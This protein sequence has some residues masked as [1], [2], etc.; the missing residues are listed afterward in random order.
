MKYFTRFSIM[1]ALAFIAFKEASA[2][3]LVYTQSFINTPAM[4]YSTT[5][6]LDLNANSIDFLSMQAVYSS[7]TYANTNFK[8]GAQSTGTITVVSTTPLVGVRGSVT[9]TM[10]TT[11]NLTKTVA[12]SD[13]IKI[14]SNTALVGQT[15]TLN[16]QIFRAG[17]DWTVAAL[18]SQTA[19]SLM[20]AI[21]AGQNVVIATVPAAGTVIYTT[22]TVSGNVGNSYQMFSSTNGALTVATLNFIGGQ[23]L[24]LLN[25]VV[26]VNG[27][28][29]LNGSDW[30]T[31]DTSSGTANS[32]SAAINSIQQFSGFGIGSGNPNFMTTPFTTTVV[33]GT[34]TVLCASTGAFCNSYGITA[35]TSAIVLSSS[36]FTGGVNNAVLYIGTATLT[37]GTTNNASTFIV[38]NSTSVTSQNISNAIQLA[39]GGV[40]NSTWSASAPI[41]AT[42]TVVGAN[43][44]YS[45]FSSTQAALKV[46]NSSMVGGT[47]PAIQGSVIVAT[48]TYGTALQLLFTKSAGTAPQN[49]VAGVTYYVTVPTTTGFKLATSQANS[50]AGTSIA[51]S[52]FTGG[53]TFAMTPLALTG[54]PSFKWQPSNDCVN[55]DDFSFTT[56]S[57]V[58][59]TTQSLATKV[60]DFQEPQFRCLGLNFIA[61]TA[62]GINL[63]IV[64]N[65]KARMAK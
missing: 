34:V 47:D 59:M 5:T 52:T 28:K 8:D 31:T 55:F 50:I 4:T 61:P 29:L 10:P 13:N 42:S 9:I 39:L 63:K 21:N 12:A 25:A 57:S 14:T 43:Q 54:T 6:I 22:A 51:I 17:I 24:P 64:G 30:S 62:G 15:L 19:L 38:S 48:N 56:V 60:W 37:A 35:S 7:G 26:T 32:L 18:S 45:W 41:S 11:A 40:I 46:S 33:N 27:S 3:Q 44:N 53:G 36:S 2:D 65:G 20:T 58:T 23:E 1:I 49:L 16:G